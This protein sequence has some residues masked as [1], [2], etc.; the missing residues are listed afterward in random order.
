MSMDD[1]D[2]MVVNDIFAFDR[3]DKRLYVD[4]GLLNFTLFIGSADSSPSPQHALFPGLN[5]RAMLRH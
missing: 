4:D 2:A 5:F 3:F 1:D